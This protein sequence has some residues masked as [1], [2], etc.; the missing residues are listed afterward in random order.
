MNTPQIEP[1]QNF[2]IDSILVEPSRNILTQGDEIFPLEPRVMD[3]LVYLA[4][5]QG[6]VCSRDDIIAAI[7]KVEYGAD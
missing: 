5:R 2:L 3:V 1:G 7:W 6:V 4:E